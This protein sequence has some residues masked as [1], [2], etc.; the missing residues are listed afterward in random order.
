MSSEKNPKNVKFGEDYY[1]GPLDEVDLIRFRLEL[2]RTDTERCTEKT[3]DS[4]WDNSTMEKLM[5]TDHIFSQTVPI[6]KGYLN[7]TRLRLITV[8]TNLMN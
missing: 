8:N 2:N 3:A 1:S 5:A 4:S 6:V 7:K